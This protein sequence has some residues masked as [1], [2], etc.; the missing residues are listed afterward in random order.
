MREAFA[1]QQQ[2]L[3]QINFVEIKQQSI[4]NTKFQNIDDLIQQKS[5]FENFFDFVIDFA[6]K[7]IV[8]FNFDNAKFFISLIFFDVDFDIFEIFNNFLNIELIFKCFLM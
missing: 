3:K 6:S 7:Q 1:K 4:I 2:L 5:L 8:F